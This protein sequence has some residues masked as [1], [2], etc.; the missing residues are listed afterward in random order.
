DPSKVYHDSDL[1][2]PH[3]YVAFYAWLRHAFD[4][5]AVV[6]LGTHGSLEWL[7]GKT[8]GLDGASAPDQLVGDLPNVYP[9]IINNPGEG[10]QAKRRS[11]AAVVD[12]LTPVMR[13]AGTYDEL[14][15]LEELADRY[16]EAGMADARTDDGEHL[17][18]L[19]REKVD[20][21]DLAV[22]LGIEGEIGEKADVRGPDE[23]GT[24]LAEGEVD[25]DAVDADELVERVH[26]Y[27]TD[28]KTTQ[29]R[30]GL[31]T[32][33]EPPAGE[34]LVEYLV[35][36]TRLENPGAPSLRE[37][38]AGVL[39]VDYDRMRAEP[40]AYD[41]ALGMTYAE[42]ADTVYET[43]LDL[44]ETL[45]D[46][47]FDLPAD[48]SAAGP[49][50][51]TLNLQV[52]DIDP[53]GDARADPG[54]HE[55]LREVL[56]FICDE[57]A[58][59]VRGA[60]DEIPRTADALA[61]AYVPPGGSGAPTRGG[62]DLL[63]TARNFYT[64]DPRKVPARSAWAVGRE[65]ADGVAERHYEEGGEYPEE[66]GVV[67]WGTPTVRTR[68]ETIAQVLALMG[69]EPVWTD[70]GRVDGVEPTPLAD[71]D[72][73][74]I[75]VTTRVSGL[76]RDAFPQAA[77]VVHDAV[78]TVV[79]LD[80][81]HDRNYVKKHVEEERER[82]ES[83]GMDADEAATAATHRVFTT[84]PGGYGAG[85]NKAVDEGNWDDRGDL[86]E[87]YVQWGGYALGSRGRVSEAHDAFERRLGNVEATV[88]IEDTD[89]QDEFDSSD[90]YAFHGGF[91]TA[92]AETRGAEPASYVGDSADP[93]D[94][95]V[96]TNE[97]KVRKAM[98]S[99]VLNPDWLDSME[100]HGYKGAGDLSTTVDVV[101]GWDATTGVVSDALWDDVAGKYALDEDRREWLREVNPWALESI[102]GTLLEAVDRGLWDADDATV[103]R[104]RDAHLR[105]DGDIEARESERRSREPT[106]RDE[107]VTSDDD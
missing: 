50:E 12:H 97:E 8:V 17:E 31:H 96:Y 52:V 67:A 90:W 15:E 13:N 75:D 89:E 58:P 32:M 88:K 74:R 40:G 59:R 44:V 30:M 83:E 92:V 3:D 85:T 55:D 11:Y 71:L 63:P 72:R 99:R 37:S 18:T 100:E 4:A 36:L 62:I 16:R 42:A 81:P 1:Q 47:D 24:T 101:L 7:P 39:G 38:V 79:A 86:A 93:D 28:V 56:A 19:L 48:E 68:G 45:A 51:S 10:T 23:A 98:R 87:V 49:G 53:L 2:P 35:A 20:D 9:Y 80:E 64:L 84:R 69:V 104:L 65:V 82:L 70:A 73:P 26:G 106:A 21:L 102:T 76:F 43:S 25:G 54:A 78:E 6:H 34:R 27:L 22:E 41:E 61:G 107:E 5:D 94:V 33:G 29:I 91:I 46:H 103:D 66:V 57:A 14:G 77:S 95:R 105:A 60:A